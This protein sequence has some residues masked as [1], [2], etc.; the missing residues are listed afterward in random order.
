MNLQSYRVLLLSEIHD[1]RIGVRG[2][3][4]RSTR[5]VRLD[6][7]S[8]SQGSSCL[9]QIF[10]SYLVLPIFQFFDFLVSDNLHNDA[11]NQ[12]F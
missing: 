5:V 3:M 8:E 6:A 12:A 7:I 11:H 1:I 2:R 10:H 4:G 9:S